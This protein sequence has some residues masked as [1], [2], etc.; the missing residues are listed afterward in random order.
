MEDKDSD[1]S[2]FSKRLDQAEDITTTIGLVVGGVVFAVGVAGLLFVI[3]H[4]F[5]TKPPSWGSQ[6]EW[7][8][9]AIGCLFVAGFGFWQAARLLARRASARQVDA[10][11]PTAKMHL[12]RDGFSFELNTDRPLAGRKYTATATGSTSFGATPVQTLEVTEEQ[13]SAAEAAAQSG[14]DWDTACRKVN[15][16]YAAWPEAVQ[17]VYRQAIQKSVEN[18]RHRRTQP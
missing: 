12:G 18:R 6:G 10:G 11:W 8:Y 2:S 17:N 15:P 3:N 5:S 1:R 14:V 4:V 9:G 7:L 16:A 13:L